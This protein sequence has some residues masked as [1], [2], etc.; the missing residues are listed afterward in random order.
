MGDYNINTFNEM[1]ESAILIQQNSIFSH[2]I[3][4]TN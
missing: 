2:H 3:I 4:T 1:K